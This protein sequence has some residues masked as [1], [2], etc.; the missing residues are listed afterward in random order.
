MF[1][2]RCRVFA[3]RCS[4]LDVGCW[5]FDVRCSM[6]DVGCW[7]LALRS[8]MTLRHSIL[9]SLALALL[10]CGCTSL[11]K[12][13]FPVGIYSV[14]STADFPEIRQAGFDVVVGQIG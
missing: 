13:S 2:L 4:M 3:V 7:M 1:D 5:L 10:A 9:T 12:R 11:P 6:F 8:S 14:P